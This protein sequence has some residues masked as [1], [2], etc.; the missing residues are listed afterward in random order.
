M[1]FMTVIFIYSISRFYDNIYVVII[2]LWIQTLITKVHLKS[3]RAAPGS[4]PAKEVTWNTI[5]ELPHLNCQT[6]FSFSA[7]DNLTSV[8]HEQVGPI[9]SVDPV[10][11]GKTQL[12]VNLVA[13]SLQYYYIPPDNTTGLKVE[14]TGC[15]FNW[16]PPKKLKY[17]KPRLGESTST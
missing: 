4:Q 9:A 3:P 10:V 14:H 7:R 17:V 11:V 6:L 1:I 16:Y 15:F 5:L 2:M 12:A 13:A 8:L